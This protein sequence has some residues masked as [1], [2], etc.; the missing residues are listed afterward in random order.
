MIE[1]INLGKEI[2]SNK[3]INFKLQIPLYLQ[4]TIDSVILQYSVVSFREDKVTI[5][6]WNKSPELDTDKVAGAIRKFSV[7]IAE[8]EEMRISNLY[9][10]THSFST[11]DLSRQR[12]HLILR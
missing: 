2:E 8:Q 11:L 1:N 5:K 9:I 4:V 6:I 10:D 3:I 12:H 7:L